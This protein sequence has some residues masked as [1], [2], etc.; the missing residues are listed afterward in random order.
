MGIVI[1]KHQAQPK[2]H[3]PSCHISCRVR[4]SNQSFSLVSRRPFVGRIA[5]AGF[6]LSDQSSH[7]VSKS[8]SA[9]LSPPHTDHRFLSRLPLR[10]NPKPR[11]ASRL[12]R[13]G[14]LSSTSSPR[15][16]RSARS[17]ASFNLS[18]RSASIASLSRSGA[19]SMVSKELI[20]GDRERCEV[21]VEGMLLKEELL[22]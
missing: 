15:S 8:R 21:G 2:S 20:E 22:A 4:E 6:A 19:S 14:G 3:A 5:Q 1:Y 10:L 11:G 17:A 12:L 16:D 13:L 9:L 18:I 7:I